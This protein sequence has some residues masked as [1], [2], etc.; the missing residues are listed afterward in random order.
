MSAMSAA[1]RVGIVVVGLIG[2]VGASSGDANCYKMS[3]FGSACLGCADTQCGLCLDLQNNYCEHN[4]RR[5][6]TLGMQLDLCS[7]HQ[8]YK[9]QI[10]TKPCHT[11]I[12]CAAQWPCDLTNNCVDGQW[13]SDSSETIQVFR[14]LATCSEGVP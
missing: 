9:Y 5:I 3:V 1:R 14:P 12:Y 2:A 7:G 6:C 8:C 11:I 10:L 4:T 13:E